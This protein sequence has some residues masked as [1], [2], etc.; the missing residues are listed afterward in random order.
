MTNYTL[1]I[2]LALCVTFC[3]TIGSTFFEH[4]A[5]SVGSVPVNIIRLCIA[6]MLLTVY[7]T[8]VRGSP[9]PVDASLSQWKWLL[10][11]GVVGF[12]ICDLLLFR[13][14]VIIGARLAQLIMAL[15]P[16]FAAFAGLMIGTEIDSSIGWRH[17]LGIMVAIAAVVWVVN[18]RRSTTERPKHYAAGV[19]MAL[20]AAVTQGLALVLVARSIGKLDAFETSQIRALAGVT[21][22][23]ILVPLIGATGATL[24]AT[25]QR[26]PMLFIALGAVFGPFLGVSLLN[27]SVKYIPSAVAQTC[28]ALVPITILPLAWL[29]NREKISTR[30][31]VGAVVAVAG[32]VILIWADQRGR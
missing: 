28:T 2:L 11:S 9:L 19:A 23:A 20:G 7:G 5:R 10:V 14:F 29:I 24:A 12:F 25:K 3:W 13:S 21:C 8:V 1:G 31:V 18:E 27:E 32:V 30:S 15:S 4:A 16:V 22:F 17:F 26:R 6:L